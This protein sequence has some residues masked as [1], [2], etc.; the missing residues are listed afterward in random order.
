MILYVLSCVGLALLV[1]LVLL[2]TV[3]VGAEVVAR[4]SHLGREEQW[5][6]SYFRDLGYYE[7]QT[8]ARH[9]LDAVGQHDLARKVMELERGR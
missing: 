9:L 6:M 7:A 8:D 2:V 4:L 3:W 5:F 1:A